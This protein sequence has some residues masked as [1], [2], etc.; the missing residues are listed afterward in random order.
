M[1]LQRIWVIV[2]R[3]AFVYRRSPIRLI[4]VLFWPTMSLLVWGFMTTFIQRS[5]EGSLP[6][7]ITFLIGAMI[8]WDILFRAQQGVSLSCPG[9]LPVWAITRWPDPGIPLYAGVVALP[10]QLLCAGGGPHPLHR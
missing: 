5:T 2:L 1:T 7:F 9:H 10:L 6:A 8:C 3:Y 4:E